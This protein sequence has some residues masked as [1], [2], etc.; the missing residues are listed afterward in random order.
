MEKTSRK[1]LTNEK[2]M[3]WDNLHIKSIFTRYFAWGLGEQGYQD[4]IKK[5]Y[6]FDTENIR[7]YFMTLLNREWVYMI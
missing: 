6:Q 3:W 4:N 5:S 7:W 1:N 2:N